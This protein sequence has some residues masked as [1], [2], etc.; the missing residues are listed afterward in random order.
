MSVLYLK[1]QELT[2]STYLTKKTI[3]YDFTLQE[4]DKVT[5]KFGYHLVKP[6]I[7]KKFK[8][9]KNEVAKKFKVITKKIITIK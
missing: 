6:K 9:D 7:L 1:Y 2:S 3:D 8:L 4:G 5:M